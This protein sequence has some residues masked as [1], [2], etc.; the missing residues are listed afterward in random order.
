MD[1]KFLA[2]CGKI[3]RRVFFWNGKLT[4]VANVGMYNCYCQKC[5]FRVIHF[6]RWT[7]KFNICIPCHIKIKGQYLGEK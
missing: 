7:P 6:N 2:E 1:I 5:G 4:K 3:W